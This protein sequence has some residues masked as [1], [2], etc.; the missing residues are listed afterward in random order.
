MTDED[1]T[2]AERVGRELLA[3]LKREPL[4]DEELIEALCFALRNTG[5]DED[6][7]LREPG[8]SMRLIKR[9]SRETTTFTAVIER[10]ERSR[11]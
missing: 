8:R 11:S 5:F 2:R 1:M 3:A 10:F 9:M 4:D 6:D 7:P